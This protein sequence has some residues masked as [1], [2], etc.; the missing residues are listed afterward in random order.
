MK[1]HKSITQTSKFS[2]RANNE[3]IKVCV[4]VRPVLGH[5]RAKD[6]VVYYPASADADGLEGI[7]VADGQHLIESKYDK[8][9]S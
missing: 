4:R 2:T 3:C 8:V 7:K 9:F 5:E 1:D 6:E